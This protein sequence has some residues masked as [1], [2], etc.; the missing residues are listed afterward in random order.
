MRYQL[1]TKQKFEI[2]KIP[3]T[4]FFYILCGKWQTEDVQMKQDTGPIPP[5]FNNFSINSF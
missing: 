3:I 5:D 2:D 4:K 1:G